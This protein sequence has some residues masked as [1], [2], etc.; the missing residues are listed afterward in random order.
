MAIGPVIGGFRLMLAGGEDAARGGGAMMSGNG[1]MATALL[2][3]AD[4][5]RTGVLHVAVGYVTRAPPRAQNLPHPPSLA[6]RPARFG[7]RSQSSTHPPHPLWTSARAS[8]RPLTE[9][10][11]PNKID[12]SPVHRSHAGAP[13]PARTLLVHSA[14]LMDVNASAAGRLVPSQ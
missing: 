14:L 3:S 10:K 7:C 8:A 4:L 6:P 11:Y 13:C 1:A 2:A 12:L 9:A 5:I